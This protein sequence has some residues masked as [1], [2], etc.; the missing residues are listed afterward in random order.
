MGKLK[1]LTGK[2]FG[3]WKV[4]KRHPENYRKNFAQWECVCACGETRVVLANS[5]LS[6]NSKGCGCR[7]RRN[8]SLKNFIHGNSY[9]GKQTPIYQTWKHIRQRCYNPDNIDYPYYGGRGIRMCNE[10]LLSFSRF[11]EDM[12]D[13]PDGMTIERIDNDGDYEPGNCRWA[14]RQEQNHNRRPDGSCGV[15]LSMKDQWAVGIRK[16]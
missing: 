8:I 5:L 4:I 6:G 10:W 9:R 11:A 3:D 15:G 12:G 2:A 16:K 14:T 7:R 1:D 13:R